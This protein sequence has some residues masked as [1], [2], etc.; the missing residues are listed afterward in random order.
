ME[1]GTNRPSIN[2]KNPNGHYRSQQDGRI[3]TK[4]G[5]VR[6][7]SVTW[8]PA[9]KQQKWTLPGAVG[10]RVVGSCGVDDL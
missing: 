7:I 6:R 2:L 1:Q 3:A 4:P 5:S 9:E 10:T 8:E